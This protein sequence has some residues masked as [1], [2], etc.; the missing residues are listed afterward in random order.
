[1]YVDHCQREIHLL[2]GEVAQIQRI[3]QTRLHQT[4]Q[5]DDNNFTL[6][7]VSTTFN[8]IIMYTDRLPVGHRMFRL[9]LQL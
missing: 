4:K 9:Q 8:I 6:Y 5:R 2:A 3:A 1:M 7:T